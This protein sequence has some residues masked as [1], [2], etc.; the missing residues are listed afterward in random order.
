[1]PS[2]SICPH[3]LSPQQ[4][5]VSSKSTAQV[6]NA[7]AL[8][9]VNLS[10]AGSVACPS[11]FNPQQAADPSSLRPHACAPPVVIALNFFPCRSGRSSL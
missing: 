7:P 1:M 3:S 5:R 9:L 4:W 11:E 10:L 8:M 2:P 6:C